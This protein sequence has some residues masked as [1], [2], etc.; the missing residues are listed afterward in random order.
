MSECDCHKVY[1]K[2]SY[3]STCH[4]EQFP[5][6]CCVCNGK[7]PEYKKRLDEEK[8]ELSDFFKSCKNKGRE[9]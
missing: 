9:T 6:D 1:G 7:N 3:C 4:Q 5:I 8:K 2:P